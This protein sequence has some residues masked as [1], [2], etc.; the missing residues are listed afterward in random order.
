M[1]VRVSGTSYATTIYFARSF[2]MYSMRY[3]IWKQSI[4]MELE[5]WRLGSRKMLRSIGLRLMLKIQ[6]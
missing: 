4:R 2:A 5:K 1:T 6:R 3:I